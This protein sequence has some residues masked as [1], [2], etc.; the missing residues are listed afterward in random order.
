MRGPGQVGGGLPLLCCLDTVA[1]PWHPIAPQ[2][3]ADL[4]LLS[5]SI[6]I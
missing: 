2:S 3:S 1:A 5:M 4:T 6:L